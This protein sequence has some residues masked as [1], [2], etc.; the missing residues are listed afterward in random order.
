MPELPEVETMVRGI[1]P[2]VEGAQLVQVIACRSPCR[3]LQIRP[4]VRQMNRLV[5]GCTVIRATRRAKRIVL[6][7]DSGWGFAIEPR[8]TGLMLLSD[9]PDRKHL[10][11]EW[12]LRSAEGERSLWFWDQRGLGTITLHSPEELRALLEP[13]RLGIDALEMTPG[14]WEGVCSATTRAI[15]VLLLDQ[16]RVAGIGNLYASEILHLARIAPQ[17]PANSLTRSQLTRMSRA[18]L[19]VLSD[20]IL[21]EGSTLGDGTYRNAL[22]QNGSYQNAHRVYDREH[23]ACQSCV[24]GVIERIVQAQRSTFFCPRC[25]SAKR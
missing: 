7:L 9:P 23:E 17:S 19:S 6:E 10:R 16:K 5:R 3:P 20:A 1:R 4:T 21:Y 15:K 2:A 14:D 22:N 12:R 18:V 11:F 25:Q 8:M 24:R 13:G